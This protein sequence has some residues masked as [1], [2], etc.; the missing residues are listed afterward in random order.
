MLM[1]REN[2]NVQEQKKP[3]YWLLRKQRIAGDAESQ[4][5]WKNNGYAAKTVRLDSVAG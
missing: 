3:D 4:G 1:S 5:L 2:N